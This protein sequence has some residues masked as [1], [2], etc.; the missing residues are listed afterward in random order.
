MNDRKHYSISATDS[1]ARYHGLTFMSG[2]AGA[3]R[4]T[5]GSSFMRGM[6]HLLT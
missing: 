6:P 1:I 2:F 3:R 5:P 4:Q